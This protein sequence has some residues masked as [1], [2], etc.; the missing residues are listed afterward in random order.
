V[1]PITGALDKLSKLKGVYF[2]WKHIDEKITNRNVGLIAQDVQEV[3]P[4]AVEFLDGDLLGINYN[5]LISL[6]IEGINELQSGDVTDAVVDLLSFAH[7]QIELLT[8]DNN[9]IF[10]RIKALQNKIRT[11]GSVVTNPQYGN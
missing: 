3:L 1:T 2:S 9:R 11:S 8:A 6:L 7:A 5:S 4:V 10:N